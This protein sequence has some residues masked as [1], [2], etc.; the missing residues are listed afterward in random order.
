MYA[1]MHHAASRNT[2]NMAPI[3]YPQTAARMTNSSAAAAMT[4]A[5]DDTVLRIARI[6]A[7][8]RGS[9]NE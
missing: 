9:S 1:L 6:V 5:A 4:L 2:V 3:R 8:Q 7:V